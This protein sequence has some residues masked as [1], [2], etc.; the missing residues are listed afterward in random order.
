MYRTSLALLLA[1]MLSSP[2][3]A[4]TA[5]PYDGKWK[6][7]FDGPRTA[8]LEGT[9]VVKGDVGTWNLDLTGQS[10]NACF[11]HE[12]PI[13]VESATGEELVFK[14]NRSKVLA[15][16]EDTMMKFKKV[17]DKTLKLEARDGRVFTLTRQ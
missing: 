14:V 12:A 1:F 11:K 13:A 15:G 5:N 17:D 6:L 3:F 10:R 8:N 2:I 4:Q 16:C 9:V 7:I